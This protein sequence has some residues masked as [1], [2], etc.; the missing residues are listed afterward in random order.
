MKTLRDGGI[1]GIGQEQ[2]DRLI[3]MDC[4]HC[5]QKEWRAFPGLNWCEVTGRSFTLVSIPWADDEAS[6]SPEG[7]QP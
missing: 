1:K 4:P 7:G 2:E 3:A 6:A 5:G